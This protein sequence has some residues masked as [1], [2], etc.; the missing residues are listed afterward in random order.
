MGTQSISPECQTHHVT[1]HVD[2]NGVFSYDNIRLKVRRGDRIVWKSLDGDLGVR[3]T[4]LSPVA[5]SAFS[6]GQDDEEEAG[7]RVQDNALYGTYKYIVAVARDGKVFIDDPE[8]EVE[9]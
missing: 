4:A 7:G 5:R 3:F 8:I 6:I 9:T 2:E 1:V